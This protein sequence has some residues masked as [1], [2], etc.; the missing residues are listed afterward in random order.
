MRRTA[1]EAIVIGAGPYGLAAAARL[2]RQGVEPHVFGDPMSFWRSMPVGMLLRSPFAA[3]NIGD[4]EDLSL[5]AYG[6]AAGVELTKPVPLDRFVE[7]GRWVQQQAVPGVDDREVVSVE[8]E[9]GGFRVTLADGDSTTAHRVV[10]AA[11]IARFAWRPPFY[12][13]LPPEVVSH[14]ADERELD[15][16]DGARVVVVGA[17]QSA[18]E[19]A[20]LLHESGADVEV[21]ARAPLVRWLALRWQH[22]LGPVT[23]MLYAPPDVGPAGVSQ[24]VARPHVFKRL[25]RRWQDRLGPRSIRPAG[26]GWLVPRMQNVPITVGREVVDAS[27]NGCVRLTLDDGTTRDADHVLLGT[28]YR[29][30]IGGYGF[31]S[32]Q[33]LEQIETIRGYPV[34]G[35]GLESSAP[36]LHFL[37]APAAW[38]FGPLMRFVAGSGFAAR[39]LA[40]E[41][42]RASRP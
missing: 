14:A 5:P 11:G 41:V 39:T 13:A 22:R 29:I 4:D 2:R 9:N 36:G 35:R 12:R 20:A 27:V 33:L 26:A 15:R 3:C 8:R 1:S 40:R 25:P 16:F 6:T 18:L 32:P 34:L 28:G 19:S 21:V 31:L 37:G 38:S 30:D 7:Y 42:A 10:V 24:L 23:R 17:G